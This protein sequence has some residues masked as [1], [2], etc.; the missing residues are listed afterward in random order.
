MRPWMRYGFSVMLMALASSSLSA[1]NA[2]VRIVRMIPNTT[3]DT[4]GLVHAP[5]A[6]VADDAERTRIVG[7]CATHLHD[8]ATNTELLLI[9]ANTNS[10]LL[11]RGDTVFTFKTAF[12]DYAVQGR[13]A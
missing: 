5:G 10:R 4:T 11:T 2:R 3:P 1:Q 8:P 12:G 7:T 6:F 13:P 9:A